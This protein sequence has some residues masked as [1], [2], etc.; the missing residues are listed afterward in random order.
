MILRVLD[1]FQPRGA[2]WSG[3]VISPPPGPSGGPSKTHL[4]PG[5]GIPRVHTARSPVPPRLPSFALPGQCVNLQ[6]WLRALTH[7]VTPLMRGRPGL[8]ALPGPCYWLVASG[9]PVGWRGGC[10]ALGLV[11]GAMCHYCLGRCSALVVCVRRSR[12]V[13]EGWGRCR[14]L[15]LPCF[16]LP[17]VS[18]C[19]P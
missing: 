3:Q 12:P 6:P 4:L 9:T 16:P 15:C 17:A 7:R 14:V 2:T 13:R 10:L 5:G 18:L 19:A 11:R 8:P 1:T